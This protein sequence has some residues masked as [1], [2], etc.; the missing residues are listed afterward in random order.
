MN[1]YSPV[2][3]RLPQ[4]DIRRI[5]DLGI[6]QTEMFG[7]D[8]GFFTLGRKD[9]SHE[10][11]FEG[12]IGFLRWCKDVIQLCEPEQVGLNE[13]GAE[14]DAYIVLANTRFNVH[15][16]TGRWKCWPKPYYYF[17]VHH[18]QGIEAS[19][20]PVVLVSCLNGNQEFI[21]IE[22]FMPSETLAMQRIIKRGECFP[23]MR[24]PSRT[25]NWLTRF[26]DYLPIDTLPSYLLQHQN[27]DSLKLQRM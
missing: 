13:M 6:R 25:D 3:I 21:R 12:E 5:H 20:C 22:G 4:E 18:G 7:H 8:R 14:F 23:G 27:Y 24:Y 16:K 17:G 26:S 10:I 9:S 19:G 2:E 1:D 11:G 15:I